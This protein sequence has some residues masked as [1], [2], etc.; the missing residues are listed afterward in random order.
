VWE[1]FGG[2]VGRTIKKAAIGS[3]ISAS[4]LGPI[5][6]VDVDGFFG[7]ILHACRPTNGHSRCSSDGVAYTFAME[8]VMSTKKTMTLNLTDAEM[9]VLEDLSAKKDIS[10]TAVIR[11]ALR[12]YQ[13]INARVEKGEKLFFEHDQ[14]KDKAEVM[15]L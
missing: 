10:K 2:A 9:S 15:V 13:L 7:Y 1:L 12:L 4:R 6:R 5:F 3:L 11:Q 14:T 8:C